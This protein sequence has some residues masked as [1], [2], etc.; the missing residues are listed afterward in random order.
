M[1]SEAVHLARLREWLRGELAGLGVERATR[2]ALVLAVGELCANSIEHAYEG[3][4]GQPIHVSILGFEDRLVLEVED[5]GR[6]F[7]A[8]RYV[9][10]DLDALPD[11]GLGIH[12]VHRIADSVSVDVRRERG[13]RWTLVKYRPGHGPADRSIVAGGGAP[14][15]RSGEAMDIEV[16]RSAAI[17][18][19]VPKGDL[20]MAA[21]DQMKR[22]LSGLVNEGSVKLLVDLGNVGY[23]DSSGMGALVATLK[24][25]RAAGGDLYLCALQDDVRAIFEMTRLIKAITIHATRGEALAAWV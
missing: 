21:A 24:V 13:T 23:I 20:D 12:L 4:G 5:F 18:V 16:T 1:S 19:V 9:A 17:T 14:P 15:A 10:P 3:R 2:A 6:A 11:H 7:D 25:A 22:V 8:V